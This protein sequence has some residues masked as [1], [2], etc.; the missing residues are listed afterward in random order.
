[1]AEPK[2][3]RKKRAAPRKTGTPESTPSSYPW[4]PPDAQTYT[5]V[6]LAATATGASINGVLNNAVNFYVQQGGLAA[7]LEKA[8]QKQADAIRLLA[9]E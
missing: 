1:M 3:P 4:R 8:H 7:D 9:G 2:K 5:A 6:R